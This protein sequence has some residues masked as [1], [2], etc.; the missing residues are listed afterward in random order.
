MRNNNNKLK[1]KVSRSSD[2]IVSDNGNLLFDSLE[3]GIS[4][5]GRLTWNF[6]HDLPIQGA[7]VS[8]VVGLYAVTV[9]GVAELIA[10]GLSANVAYRMFAFGEPLPKAVEKTIKFEMGELPK[11]DIEL[12]RESRR[13]T[14]GDRVVQKSGRPGRQP[15]RVLRE[16]LP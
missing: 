5:A 1:R 2:A 9:F 15:S 16:P 6:F 4:S 7:I 11:T 14:R 8:G 10:A 13:S 12:W 3:D